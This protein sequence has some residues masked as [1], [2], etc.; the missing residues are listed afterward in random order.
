M[1]KMRLIRCLDCN[2]LT[3]DGSCYC[4]ALADAEGISDPNS[5]RSYAGRS[6]KP[7]RHYWH[8]VAFAGLSR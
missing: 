4:D 5:A 1:L 3:A 6:R 2:S 7:T 8:A